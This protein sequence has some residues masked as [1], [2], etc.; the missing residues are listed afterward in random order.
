[1]R[2][3]AAALILVAASRA[4]AEPD[5]RPAPPP[6]QLDQVTVS[7]AP[8]AASRRRQSTASKIVIA[9]EDLDRYGDTQLGDVLRRLPGVTIG[10]RPGR[11]GDIRLRGLGGGFT[12]IL[13]DGERA[14]AGFAVE[15][16]P[17]DQ[18]E[19]IEVLRAPTA[20]TGA[21]AVAG[22]LNIVLREPL[23]RRGQE[24]RVAVGGDHGEPQLDGNWTASTKAWG[25]ALLGTLSLNANQSRRPNDIDLRFRSLRL[26]TGEP[27]TGS[28]Q[29]GGNLTRSRGLNG[30]ARLRWT[31]NPQQQ[32]TLSPSF[33]LSDTAS[34]TALTVRGNSR[35]DAATGAQQGDSRVL[36]LNAH[37]SHRAAPNSRW[38]WRGGLGRSQFDSEH[39]RRETQLGGLVRRQHDHSRTEDHSRNLGGKWSLQTAREHQWVSGW[40]WERG[41]RLQTRRTLEAVGNDSL[42]PKP[43]LEEF[44]DS[45]AAQTRRLAAY[46]QNEW[47]P[48]PAWSVYAGLRWEQLRTRGDGGGPGSVAGASTTRSSVW[49]PLFHL[50][51]KPAAFP[52]DQLRLSLTRSYRAPGLNDLIAKPV[53][54]ASYPN[55]AN[56]QTHPDSAGNPGLRP[57]LATG[58]DLSLEHWLAGGGVLSA[59]AYVREIDGLI[60]RLLAQERVPWDPSPRWV[61][62]PRNLDRARTMGVELEVKARLDELWPEAPEAL[63]PLLLRA[64]LALFRSQ[65]DGI[66]GPDNRLE[67]QPRGTANLGLDYLWA[68]GLR[69]GVSW[70]YVPRTAVQQTPLLRREDNPRRV[71]DAY[72]QWAS[73]DPRDGIT[74]RLSMANLLPADTLVLTQV[75]NGSTRSLTEDSKRSFTAWSL[76]AETRF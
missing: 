16:L 34:D 7:G 1:M 21:R 63:G 31:I 32:L 42:R 41:E 6:A 60:R 68:Q 73:G 9:R 25:D 45:L 52:R 27:S 3:L 70:G 74:W 54:N 28:G 4:T 72:L 65:V 40:E 24:L 56:P 64:N 18:V 14:P 71:L 55:G 59:S 58:L 53:V 22:T 10:G 51:W 57:E 33:F 75:D 47:N 37:G 43:G 17:P 39:R 61:S 8:T 76:R 38:E 20:E 13:I 35:Y 36:R 62:R 69:A 46:T 49:S 2:A 48:S 26:D 50:L 30:N 19:R 12:Q 23:A 44:G 29:Q 15:Q 66:P 11:G 67:Q 5:A